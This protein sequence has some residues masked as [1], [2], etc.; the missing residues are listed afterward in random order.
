[1]VSTRE[2]AP[3]GQLRRKT[4]KATAHGL[5][6]SLDWE[7]TVENWSL[8]TFDGP[9]AE[10]FGV[11][12]GEMKVTKGKLGVTAEGPIKR[13]WKFGYIQNVLGNQEFHYYQD[14]TE[15]GV[16]R[17]E[18][19]LDGVKLDVGERVRPWYTDP[20]EEF[21]LM[22]NWLLGDLG[23][24][25]DSPNNKW[26]RWQL[27]DGSPLLGF[28]GETGFITWAVAWHEDYGYILLDRFDWHIKWN[29]R[30]N[31]AKKI[32]TVAGGGMHTGE[33][34]FKYPGSL[35]LKGTSA[36]ESGRAKKATYKVALPESLKG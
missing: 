23:A 5:T 24:M 18:V 30:R 22:S 6:F 19:N 11:A 28:L 17:L 10:Q 12:A 35:V 15:G 4:A 8:V 1:M 9:S 36:N 14:K 7:P 27:S 13:G 34:L 2:E 3:R 29:G 16:S 32:E 26:G 31:G 25:W 20:V 33:G 21:P